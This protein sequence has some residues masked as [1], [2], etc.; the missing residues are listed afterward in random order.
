MS[1]HIRLLSL[2]D[3]LTGAYPIQQ[4]FIG[5]TF[6]CSL[7]PSVQSAP[8][9]F[10]PDLSGDIQLVSDTPTLRLTLPSS[11]PSAAQSSTGLTYCGFKGEGFFLR[12]ESWLAASGQS[13][14]VLASHV[15]SAK[16]SE[17]AVTT[18][19]FDSITISFSKTQVCSQYS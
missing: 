5:D 8:L 17:G 18:N 7:Y 13:T 10:S 2:L 14:I 3:Q 19:L 1:C 16:L 9:S 15:V 6:G 12:R 11:L 4:V